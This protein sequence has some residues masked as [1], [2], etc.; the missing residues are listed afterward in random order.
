MGQVKQIYEQHTS[1]R[2]LRPPCYQLTLTMMVRNEEGRYLSSMLDRT[3]PFIDCAIIIDDAST[4]RT[5]ELCR[6][7]LQHIPYRILCIKES[8]FKQEYE[9]RSLQ[10]RETIRMSPAWI[11][12]LDAD[13][14]LE[15]A[16]GNTIEDVLRQ[17]FV[18]L[19][20]FRLY[21]MWDAGHYRDDEYWYAHRVYRPFLVRYRGQQDFSWPRM[22][23]HC[24][25]FPIEIESLPFAL[26]PARIQHFGWANLQDRIKKAKRYMELDPK[27]R[28]GDQGQY[29]SILDEQPPLKPWIE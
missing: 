2:A 14:L 11:L 23:Q 29:D 18:D 27:A 21:D 1:S 3:I 4:D 25:R 16:F 10:W 20:C 12:N 24:G 19:F 17:Q 8:G 26:H 7:K 6:H 13:E 15:T 9:L 22:N 28:Y 5:V